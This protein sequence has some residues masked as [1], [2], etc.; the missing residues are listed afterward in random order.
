MDNQFDINRDL[1]TDMRVIDSEL[2]KG[3]VVGWYGENTVEV[4]L[5]SGELFEYKQQDANKWLTLD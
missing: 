2:G 5:D 4:Q 3:T 1:V